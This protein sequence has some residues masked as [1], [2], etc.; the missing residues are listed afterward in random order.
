[1]INE[2]SGHVVVGGYN[3]LAEA[4]EEV[5]AA[6]MPGQYLW[7]TDELSR[8]GYD[9]DV[10]SWGRHSRAKE[11][12]KRMRFGLGDLHQ[13]RS[14]LA[15]RRPGSVLYSF[16]AGSL[17]GLAYARA[18]R[19]LRNPLLTLCHPEVRQNHV[20]RVAYRAISVAMCLSRRTQDELCRRHGR[21]PEL[22]PF[23]P[24]GPDLS[25]PLYVSRPEDGVVLST[26]KSNRDNVTLAR[27]LAGT[28][29]RG[30]IYGAQPF[31]V[32][33]ATNVEF[34]DPRAAGR[35]S[36]P[37]V[38][39]LQDA[40]SCSVM[41]ISVRDP[42]R[43]TGLSELNH[44]LALGKPIVMT[45]S[46]YVD[47]DVEAIGCGV[48]VGANDV[49]GWRDAVVGLMSDPQS[50]ATMGQRGRAY[51]EEHWNAQLFGASVKAAVQLAIS[52]S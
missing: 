37:H 8:A 26:G 2:A 36:F 27:A 5:A 30:R 23:A 20:D 12:S 38:V 16:D 24:W 6:R 34:I 39:P 1:V 21:A 14:V 45:R 10:A 4:R 15:L 51:A 40:Q 3:P 9:L 52:T 28:E 11:A 18:G 48:L 46:P 32:P 50:R 19:L 17:H 43:L 44:A 7:G 25:S 47:L 42:E 33:P 22:T 29:V 13:E 35:S 49:R 31:D 41:A